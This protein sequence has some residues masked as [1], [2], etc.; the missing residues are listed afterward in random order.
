MDGDFEKVDVSS[1]YGY[2][3]IH[4]V[5]QH[6]SFWPLIKYNYRNDTDMNDNLQNVDVSSGVG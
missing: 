4:T 2:M 3:R 5:L 6:N 1:W